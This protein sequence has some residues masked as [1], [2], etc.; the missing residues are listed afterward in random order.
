M[1]N[2]IKL[3]M[4]ILLLT[5]ACAQEKVPY[6]TPAD[7]LAFAEDARVEKRFDDART[8]FAYCIESNDQAAM[9]S[10]YFGLVKLEFKAKKSE[11]A[12]AAFHSLCELS[13]L[14]ETQLKELTDYAIN[15]AQPGP[16]QTI[17][18]LALQEGKISDPHWEMAKKAIHRLETE[19]PFP[20]LSSI[21]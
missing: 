13:P 11:A 20:D 5:G 8:A 4:A 7:A 2:S 14:E 1:S 12:M 17:F 6:S 18:D 19:G 10:A 3:G 9:Q 21:H 15:C 16:A